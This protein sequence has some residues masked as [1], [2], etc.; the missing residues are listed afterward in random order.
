[1]KNNYLS[2]LFAIIACL[3]V[4]V[5]LSF[6]QTLEV[7]AP[8]S[9]AGTYTAAG[10]AFGG[11]GETFSG[12]IVPVTDNDGLTTACVPVDNSV[13]DV[14]GKIAL[15]D[16][17]GCAFSQKVANAEAAGAIA[18]ILCNTDPVEV[19]NAPAA[20]TA[21]PGIPTAM[22]NGT[23]C[24]TIRMET[25]V[26]ATF[27]G[28]T[29]ENP[30]EFFNTA[31]PVT[32]GT[33]TVD[34]LTGAG[35]LYTGFDEALFYSY[36][37]TT[38]GVLNI[39][40]CG[41][42]ANTFLSLWTCGIGLVSQNDDDCDDGIGGATAS[43]AEVLVQ[44]GDIV[45]FSFDAIYGTD[46]F[47][48]S[49]ELLPLPSVPVTF[50]V[51]MEQETVSGDGVWMAYEI[52][53]NGSAESIQLT[54]NSDGTYSGTIDVTTLD[55]VY[56][57]Y[58]NG[59]PNVGNAEMDIPDACGTDIGD[60]F[61]IRSF[62][63]PFIEAGALAPVCFNL[64]TNCPLVNVTYTVDMTN[65]GASP[66]G[67]SMLV[68]GP[69]V[70]DVNDVEVF[71]MTDNGDGTW[72]V[73]IERMTGDTLGYVFLNGMLDVAN[74]ESVPEECGL[75]S[76]FGFN[77]RPQIVEGFDDFEVDAVCFNFCGDCPVEGI[78]CDDPNVIWFEDFEDQ[79]VGAPPVNEFIVPWPVA[80]IILGN[81]SSDF[82]ASG[83]NSHLI[84]GDGT[85]VDP[86]YLLTGETLT[87][88]HYVVS[89]NMYVPA[90]SEAYYNF[91]KDA[92][93]AVEWAVEVFFN[94]DG[95]GELFAGNTAA[96]ATFNYPE[97]EWFA[98]V[99]VID[100]DNDLIRTHIDGRWVTS[101]PLNFDASSQGN[102]QSIGGVNFYPSN[103]GFVYYIDDFLVA[104]IPEPGEGL[105]CQ[106]A[107][108]V[109]P[110]M[111]N[112]A[113]GELDCFGG[114]FFY[115]TEDDA[116]LQSRWYSYTAEEDG[117]ITV[118]S[119]NGGDDTRAY[120]LGGPCGDLAIL[121]ANDDRCE[122]EPGGDAWASLAEA[123]VT[124]GETYYIFWDDYW[125]PGAYSWELSFTGG[126]LPDGNFCA[127]AIAVDP[128]VYTIGGFGE[129]SV[130]GG[131]LGAS[132]NPASAVFA[133]QLYAGAAWYTYTPTADETIIITSCDSGEDTYVNVYTGECGDISSLDL[134]AS[135]DDFADCA[136]S[137]QLEL[138]VTAGTTYYIEWMDLYTTVAHEWE[139][140]AAVSLTTVT[141]QVDATI[142]VESGEISADGIY[143][144]GG[145]ND[146]TGEPMNEGADNIWTLTLDIEPGTYTYKFQNG[147]GG[148]ETIDTSVGDD[149]TVGGY[150]DRE[151]VVEDMEIT[152]DLVCFGYCVT[153]NFVDTDEEVLQ[154]SV[155]IFPN[156]ARDLLNVQIDLP[157]AADNLSVRL[158]NAF[159]QVVSEQ[160][161]GQLQSDNIELDLS[162]VPAGAYMLQVRDGQAQHTQSVIV[163]K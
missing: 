155:D 83:S 22:I 14:T 16:R 119:C 145:F 126:A 25:G 60:G 156:P 7:T 55:T 133:P 69:G 143:L 61:N 46:G 116:G 57:V 146:F 39:N 29:L 20:C 91:Q 80:G 159:G 154:A 53:I 54:D 158:V 72:S 36:T 131:V 70:A 28:E 84:T 76:G 105:Y 123:P 152:T 163:Q 94:G 151:V 104:Q 33:Y 38:A 89:W 86:V 4:S 71:P 153:C 30:N 8:M 101:W 13:A 41:G 27:T 114:G 66:D 63:N 32:E 43:S 19:I 148:W 79:T 150:G 77:I 26:M 161:L 15:I 47:D 127:S 81:V 99:Q 65:Q 100:I 128:G 10:A 109:T 17:G 52:G 9:I 121:S 138:D 120:I 137:S 62:V 129:A 58:T 49:V 42:G 162:K 56:Y 68:G 31:E 24:A 102:L 48:F 157:Q 12:E 5:S 44:P 96:R 50:T 135:N 132:T 113:D 34:M 93:P 45:I 64:C 6:A 118:S 59:L 141:F 73:T 3:G 125:G 98:V 92:T 134:I 18:V 130:G 139:L 160:Y 95:T 88:G 21:N 85:D 136:P 2:R 1:M 111:Y 40:S 35:S 149:C 140:S 87:E 74:L 108:P 106:S 78:T 147:P 97:D 124:A 117:Y 82:A 142:L 37:A 107:T 51:N 115:D 112:I 122:L 23:D 110:G 144:A 103:T 90:G 75:P 67:V 11:V